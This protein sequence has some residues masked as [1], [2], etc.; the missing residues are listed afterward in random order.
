MSKPMRQ[1]DWLINVSG[2]FTI[3]GFFDTKNSVAK[4]AN[5][6]KYFGGGN[7]TPVVMKDRAVYD[8]LVIGRG[9]VL[10]RD[11]LTVRLLDPY[12]DDEDTIWTIKA[13]PRVNGRPDLGNAITYR[14]SL[15]R[16]TDPQADSEAT[17]TTRSNFELT[18]SVVSK[19]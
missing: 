13:T 15:I 7:D 9:Y 6:G 16:V 2:P 1:N 19:L 17:G 18:F 14:G 11:T 12:V 5:T 4:A 8:D 10:Q 3:P